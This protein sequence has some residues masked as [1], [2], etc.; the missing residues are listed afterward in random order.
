MISNIQIP[1]YLWLL[2]IIVLF[3]LLSG[4]NSSWQILWDTVQW[5]QVSQTV[6]ELRLPRVIVAAMVGASLGIAGLLLQ[7]VTGNRLADPGIIG[8]NQGAALAVISAII[9]L[10]EITY[11]WLPLIGLTGGIVTAITLWWLCRGTASIALILTG[12]GLSSLLSALIGCLMVL[13]ETQ[14]LATIMT[15]LAGSFSSANEQ[16][17]I[18]TIAWC[19]LLLPLAYLACR[20]ITPMLLD[21][22]SAT[23]LGSR[24]PW[25]ESS[26]LL[27]ACALCSVAVAAAGTLSF[28]GLLAPHLAR[29]LH[30]PQ[31]DKLAL[32]VLCYGAMLTMLADMLGRT[33]FAPIQI[34]AGL[35]LA[36]AG[37]PVFILILLWQQRIRGH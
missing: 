31:P 26:C 21:S 25:M 27:I 14:R 17:L 12:I 10:P 34:P 13:T 7:T 1:T 2:P 11:L 20:Q 32:P 28:A 18:N 16:T 19:L 3:C 37:V 24:T 23:M 35:M 29:K 8:V 4:S 33:L 30:P 22:D 36:I 9:W 15:W 6:L 5:Q